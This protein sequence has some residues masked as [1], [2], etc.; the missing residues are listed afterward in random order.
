VPKE[1]EQ[2]GEVERLTTA[3]SHTRLL[4]QRPATAKPRTW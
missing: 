3:R 1:V 2:G 4:A